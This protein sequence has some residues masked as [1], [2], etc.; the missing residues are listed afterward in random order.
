MQTMTRA[1]DD[2][3]DITES[4]GA[5]ALAV[6]GG[7]AAENA[8]ADRLFDDPYAQLFIDAAG[9]GM[10]SMFLGGALPETLTDIDPQMPA[11]LQAMG[12]YIASRT[13]FFDEFFLGAARAGA[14]Q[15]VILAAGLDARAWRL[16]WPAGTT[17]YELDQP[18]VL[19][20]KAATLRAAGAHPRA[21]QVNVAVDLRDDWPEAL[22]QNG[23]DASVPTAWSAEG[24]LPYLPAQAQ[25]LLF[26]RIN[27]LSAPGSRI[28]A[29][30]FGADGFNADSLA[31]QRAVM[32]RYQAAAAASQD[33]EL[34]AADNLADLVYLEDRADV[35]DW[36]RGHGWEV[37]VITAGELMADNN[38]PLPEDLDDPTPPSVF[39]SALRPGLSVRVDGPQ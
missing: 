1:D 22:R 28:A 33:A 36:L 9:D 24:L 16:D 4:V 3:W 7:R 37:T 32:E 21:T 15:A 13:V 20:F 38:R 23:F 10:W 6:A 25:D 19:E 2:T 34:P 17:V 26:E 12:D 5:T 39:I 8:R 31:R 29:E 27:T 18:K 35:A 14:H 30:A 11:R